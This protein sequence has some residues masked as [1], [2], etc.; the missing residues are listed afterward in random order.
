MVKSYIT[1]Q[2]ISSN[3]DDDENDDFDDGGG[4]LAA[5]DENG[6]SEA[7]IWFYGVVHFQ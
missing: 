2:A 5:D 1:L 7:P 6:Q 4:C 3:D